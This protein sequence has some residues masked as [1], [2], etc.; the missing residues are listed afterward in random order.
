MRCQ[1]TSQRGLAVPVGGEG[2][3][4]EVEVMESRNKPPEPV[5][6]FWSSGIPPE[7]ESSQEEPEEFLE[8]ERARE[9][10]DA[11]GDYLAGIAQYAL[12]TWEEEVQLGLAVETWLKLT[13]LRQE[14]QEAQGGMPKPA[15]L[16]IIIYQ[17]L[18]SLR[19]PLFILASVLG[20]RMDNPSLAGLLFMPQVRS[21][22][23]SALSPEVK[24]ALAR[25]KEPEGTVTAN[26]ASLSAL[27][28]LLP[29]LPHRTARG[30]R[31]RS[32]RPSGVPRGNPGGLVATGRGGRP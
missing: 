26:I 32:N 20:E 12:L 16:G 17:Q 11:V 8:P 3:L 6:D 10:L 15:E 27:S 19:G 24:N 4:R 29:P 30:R 2:R 14:F 13:E 7:E 21:A 9:V 18:G 25:A 22:L 28:R 23:H 1:V 5:N 31:R